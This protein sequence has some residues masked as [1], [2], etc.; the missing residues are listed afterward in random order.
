[1]TIKEKVTYSDFEV[2]FIFIGKAS[3]IDLLTSAFLYRP[4]TYC[5]MKKYKLILF[6]RQ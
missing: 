3:N 4:I 6:A 1:M 2:G 5:Q